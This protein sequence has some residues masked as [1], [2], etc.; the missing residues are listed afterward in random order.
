M[1]AHHD[2]ELPPSQTGSASSPVIAAYPDGP[3]ID[4]HWTR[5]DP[6]AG[7]ASGQPLVLINGLGSPLVSFDKGFVA[8]FVDR[9]FSVV[10]FDNRD[11]GRSGRVFE[12]RK[13]DGYRFDRP[14]YTLVEMARDVAAVLDT[15]GWKSAHVLGQSM[16]GMIAQ[17]MTGRVECC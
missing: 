4:L 14:P 17:Q 13:A 12:D 8:E 5:H 1:V 10:R 7:E 15:V 3:T 2:I 6:P 11:A 16:G 9:G